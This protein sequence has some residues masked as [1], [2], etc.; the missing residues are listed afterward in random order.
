MSDFG[1][2]LKVR[3]GKLDLLFPILKQLKCTESRVWVDHALASFS[4]TY[5]I[6]LEVPLG[7]R[8]L[9]R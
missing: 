7:F 6:A 5:L 9:N 1:L 8:C 3:A 4:E 2:G